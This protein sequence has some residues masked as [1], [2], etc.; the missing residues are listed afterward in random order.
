M[1]FLMNFIFKRKKQNIKNKKKR[2]KKKKRIF[3]YYK[4][5]FIY[6]N[7]YTPFINIL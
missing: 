4:H 6:N 3:I 5:V 1:S 7:I 2:K